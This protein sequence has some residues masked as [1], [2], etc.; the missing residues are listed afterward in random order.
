MNHLP[1]ELIALILRYTSMSSLQALLGFER[2]KSLIHHEIV[3]RP[4]RMVYYRK[5]EEYTSWEDGDES[6]PSPSS[7]GEGSDEE[8]LPSHEEAVAIKYTRE[9]ELVHYSG[10]HM[11]HKSGQIDTIDFC[12]T[13]TFYIPSG[14]YY[15]GVSWSRAYFYLT[16]LHELFYQHGAH[17][18]LLRSDVLHLS[19]EG[20]SRDLVVITLNGKVYFTPSVCLSV[21]QW[22]EVPL[23]IEYEVREIKLYQRGCRYLMILGTD[24]ILRVYNLFSFTLEKEVPDT[25]ATFAYDNLTYGESCFGYIK[26]CGNESITPLARVTIGHCEDEINYDEAI[27][28]FLDGIILLDFMSIPMRGFHPEHFA[29]ADHN[30]DYVCLEFSDE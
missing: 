15:P 20:G 17:R 7:E 10:Y 21:P 26:H 23:K 27:V 18:R 28:P 16:P 1:L 3:R 8:E 4:F 14:R 24:D 29:R 19:Y 5:R 12:S 2:L 13:G 6:D 22:T 25:V 9:E 11:S 30:L